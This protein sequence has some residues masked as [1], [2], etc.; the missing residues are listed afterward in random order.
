M[1]N[2]KKMGNGKWEMENGKWEKKHFISKIF[3]AL[4]WYCSI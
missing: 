1:E 4:E 2:G 3:P